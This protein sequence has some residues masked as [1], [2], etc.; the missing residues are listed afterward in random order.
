MDRIIKFRVWDKYKR[1]MYPMEPWYQFKKNKESNDWE[2]LPFSI[3]I[4]G[5]AKEVYVENIKRFNDLIIMQFTGLLDSKG[6]EIYEGDVV[7]FYYDKDDETRKGI[8]EYRGCCFWLDDEYLHYI[9]DPTVIGN[10]YENPEL[11]EEE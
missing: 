10:I 4:E 7:E 2:F 11:V 6:R 9:G 1:K 5:N 8:I 3:Q